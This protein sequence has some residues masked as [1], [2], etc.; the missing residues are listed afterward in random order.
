AVD[1]RRRAAMRRRAVAER[2]EHAAKARLDLGRRIAGDAKGLEHDV[3]E[4]VADR[5]RTE[6]DAV[7]HDVV[8]IGEDLQRVLGLERFDAAL[9]HRERVVAELDLPA[10]L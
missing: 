7:A 3:G 9:R 4:M 10:L 6:L 8:L 5:A 1:A 2:L